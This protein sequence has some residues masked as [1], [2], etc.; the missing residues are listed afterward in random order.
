MR[1]ACENFFN[2]RLPITGLAAC[3]SQLPD[4]MIMHHCFNKWLS[5]AQVR[6]ALG[7]LL[8]GS[9]LLRRHRLEPVR[10][11]WRFEHLRVHLGVRPD[12]AILALF[13]ENRPELLP[14]DAERVLDEFDALPAV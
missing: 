8:A 5:P 10:V 12:N 2:T 13:L 1:T 4:G 7:Q 11:T 14:A 6:Q 3:A 9:E